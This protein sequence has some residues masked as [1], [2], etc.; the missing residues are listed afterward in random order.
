ML[1]KPSKPLRPEQ[2]PRVLQQLFLTAQR[3]KLRKPRTLLQQHLETVQAAE[4]I[5]TRTQQ[6][7]AQTAKL[8]KRN[9]SHS[10]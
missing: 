1:I 8:C 10:S 2:P 7:R 9:Q 4:A 6:L 3:A 5:H